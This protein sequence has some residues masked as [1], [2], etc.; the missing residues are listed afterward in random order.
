MS[1][2]PTPD[3]LELS[4]LPALGLSRRRLTGLL[5]EGAYERIGPGQYLRAG[6]ADD[7]TAAWMAIASKRPEATLC[8]LTA[9]SLHDLTDEIPSRSHIAIPRGRKPI[10]AH[11]APIAWHSFDPHTFEIGRREYQLPGGRTI[12][13]YSPERTII[14]LF[15]LRHEWGSD[16]A[17]EALK[18]W[19]HTSGG[20]SSALLAQ[21]TRFPK[22]K[23]AIRHALE[24]LL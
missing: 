21:A 8:L 20:S 2:T 17:V 24:I 11:T 14:D 16:L 10:A 7:T 4:E 19:L 23:P 9:A 5:D 13:L 22:A 12:G 18:R 15:R 3:L 6:A 1:A